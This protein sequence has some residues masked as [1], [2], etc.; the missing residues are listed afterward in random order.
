MDGTRLLVR[1]AND[2]ENGGSC[3]SHGWMERKELAQRVKTTWVV[4]G[5]ILCVC[6][7]WVLSMSSSHV[8][9]HEFI[10]HGSGTWRLHL[11]ESNQVIHEC[12]RVFVW[13][14][15]E[16]ACRSERGGSQV[17]NA[18][19]RQLWSGLTHLEISFKEERQSRRTVGKG[20]RR[21]FCIPCQINKSKLRAFTWVKQGSEGETE[22]DTRGGVL[23]HP[24][25]LYD[26]LVSALSISVSSAVEYFVRFF[27]MDSTY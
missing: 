16:C 19:E 24:P 20:R 5:C 27:L 1:V 18:S 21:C 14:Q 9:R 3:G 23:Q 12:V 7:A 10:A 13:A 25:V 11:C 2:E 8:R 26:S 6:P 17:I 15:C 22:W 4:G